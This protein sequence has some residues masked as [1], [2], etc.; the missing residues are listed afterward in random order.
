M[1]QM[2]FN[3]PGQFSQS[4]GSSLARDVTDMD[5]SSHLGPVASRGAGGLNVQFFYGQVRTKSRN[6][7]TTGRI[8]TRLFVAKQPKGDRFTVAIRAITEDEAQRQFPREFAAFKQYEDVPTNGTPLS[9]LPGISQSQIGMLVINGLRSIED[10]AEI[11]SDAVGQLGLEVISAHRLAK[12][13]VDR[14]NEQGDVIKSA[15]I[16]AKAQMERDAL[17]RRLAAMEAHNQQ[18]QAQIAAMQT[19]GGRPAPAGDAGVIAVD[20]KDDLQWDVSKM[21]D[22]FDDGP[23]TASGNDDLGDPDPLR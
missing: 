2:M 15:E 23:I 22:P 5:L 16:E 19:M 17:A 12:R 3:T 20:S 7:S 14:R 9:E 13:W 21:P 10:L 6:A 8:E 4:G 1:N 11:S 18:L